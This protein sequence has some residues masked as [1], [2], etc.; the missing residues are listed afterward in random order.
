MMAFINLR[1]IN[2]PVIDRTALFSLASWIFRIASF[3]EALGY[4]AVVYGCG[5]LKKPPGY[6]WGSFMA[7]N[8]V[9]EDANKDVFRF[10]P[11]I[12]YGAFLWK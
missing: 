8:Y 2:K 7:Y 11:I 1:K 10:L 5:S 6:D 4:M 9:S 3:K 12:Y